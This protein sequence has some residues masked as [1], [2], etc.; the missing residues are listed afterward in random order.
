M[1]DRSLIDRL[2]DL[3]EGHEPE[4]WPVPIHK[5]DLKALLD[6]AMWV[7][8]TTPKP[9]EPSDRAK[10]VIDLALHPLR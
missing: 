9:I 2:N 8:D 10:Y 3:L 6:Q 5:A 1:T 4:A 7:R